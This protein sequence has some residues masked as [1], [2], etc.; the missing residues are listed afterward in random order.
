MTLRCA[1][2]GTGAWAASALLPALRAQAGVEV[3]ACVGGTLEEGRR[4]AS[5]HAV[6]RAYGA[7][8]EMLAQEALDVAVV[9]TPD[10]LHAGAVKAF[11]EAGVAVY[12]EKPLSN[13]APTAH[14]LVT[15]QRT[16]NVPATVGYSF[17]FN[18]A[19]QALKADLDAGHFGEIW[20][21]E[22]AEHNPQFHPDGGK[23]M[24]WKG[25]PRQAAGGALFEYGSHVIDMGAWL[26]GPIARVSSSFKRVLAGARL[27]DIATLQLDFTSGAQGLL[28]S[29]WV[30][31]GGFPGT[32]IKLH[33]SKAVGEVLI[34]DRMPEGQRYHVAPAIGA[35]GRDRDV[36]SMAL[37]RSD[38]ATRHIAAF[39][40]FIRDRGAPQSSLPTLSQAAHVQDVLAAALRADQQWQ[41]VPNRSNS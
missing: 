34:D 25:D 4:F 27:D 33:G 14:E 9:A 35:G 5:E 8:D 23:A 13:D 18:P 32:R 39:L 24:N 15:L 26:L 2:V 36:E 12:C 3:V 29:S 21:I 38:A 41:A 37:P 6:P 11:L 1:L 22:L 28:I 10:H 16:T 30:L 17:R 7:L 40:A 19:V 20:L 31:S